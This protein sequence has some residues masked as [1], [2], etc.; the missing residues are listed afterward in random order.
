M[1]FSPVFMPNAHQQ[2]ALLP[3]VTQG[4][5]TKVR[6]E[7]LEVVNWI[8]MLSCLTSH[9]YFIDSNKNSDHSLA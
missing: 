4:T 9:I 6:N 5:G 3:V 7:N 8:L 1:H 2:G